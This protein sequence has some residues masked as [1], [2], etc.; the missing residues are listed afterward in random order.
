MD[1]VNC[2]QSRAAGKKQQN[3]ACLGCLFLSVNI[4][5]HHV[6]ND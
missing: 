2:L 1:T 6:A 3:A 4:E 5:D